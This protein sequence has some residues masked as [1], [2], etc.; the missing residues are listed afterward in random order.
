MSTRSLNQTLGEAV[1]HHQRGNLAD[2]ERL[3]R[4]VLQADK[5]NFDALHL[6]GIIHTQ[7]GNFAEAVKF[8]T[9]AAKRNP[10]SADAHSN[11]GNALMEAKRHEEAIAS[12]GKAISLRPGFAEA[13]NNLGNAL[14]TV[15]RHEQAIASCRRALAIKPD[16]AEAHHNIGLAHYGLDRHEEVV[17]SY[18]S[19]LAIKPNDIETLNNLG[20]ALSD[21]NRLPEAI[22]VFE[23][24]LALKPD[25][26][27]ARWNR[28][29]ARLTMGDLA[30]GWEDYEWRWQANVTA[31]MQDFPQPLWLGDGD[32]AGKTILLHADQGLGDTLQLVRY[33]P[34][35]KARGARRVVLQVLPA[36]KELMASAKAVDHVVARGEP[37]PDFDCHCPLSSLPRGFGTRLNN[38]PAEV[39]YLQPAADRTAKWRTLLAGIDGPRIGLTWAG[40]RTNRK[41]RHR[42]I[43]LKRLLPIIATPGVRF[44]TLQKEVP[45][46]DRDTFADLRD[47][48]HLGDK[49]DDFADTAAAV[50][51]LDLMISIDTSMVHLAG[52]LGKP[53]WVLMPF[54]QDWR[55]LLDREDSPW[56][57]SARL[58]RQ[59]RVGDWDSPIERVRAELLRSAPRYASGDSRFA[60]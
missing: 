10:A 23:K 11:L 29:L 26:A 47:V 2:A 57:P 14:N 4:T 16:L 60:L 30:N 6:L 20:L 49:L 33:A 35:V 53:V 12:Y 19:A 55:W 56:Y 34:L 51:M 59:P 45:D 41:L 58:F 24:A 54:T 43:T 13:H 42:S 52:A 27:Q 50:T 5:G 1:A 37:L 22:D 31:P 7:R 21:L 28:G 36:L 15:Q 48:V 17:A 3:Y 44:V 46:E 8:L 39:P 18:R 40:N 25:F 9:D 32:L 38:I